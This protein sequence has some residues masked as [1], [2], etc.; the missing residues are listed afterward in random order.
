[1]DLILLTIIFSSDLLITIILIFFFG[2]RKNTI[3]T[4][5]YCIV[6]SNVDCV[7][8]GVCS[9][10]KCGPSFDCPDH[11]RLY[12]TLKKEWNFLPLS[13]FGML[14]TTVGPSGQCMLK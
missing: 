4:L 14:S 10:Y 2:M 6:F 8:M 11:L 7:H 9:V 3:L 1:M 13:D 5:W 12:S